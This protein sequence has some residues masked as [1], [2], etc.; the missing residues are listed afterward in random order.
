MR[1]HFAADWAFGIKG[2]I[3]NVV[4]SNFPSDLRNWPL[5]QAFDFEAY[6]L[7]EFAIFIFKDKLSGVPAGPADLKDFPHNGYPELPPKKEEIELWH[8]F[9]KIKFNLR[10]E[11]FAFIIPIHDCGKNDASEDYKLFTKEEKEFWNYQL[12]Y[13]ISNYK[14]HL[15]SMKEKTP[16]QPMNITYNVSGNN[17]RVNI[18]STDNSVNIVET[19]DLKIFQDL[20]D[21]ASKI[22]NESER[23]NV[24]ESIEAMEAEAGKEKFADK[25]KNFISTAANHMTLFAPFIPPLTELITKWV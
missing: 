3:E 7:G 24:I 6:R 10:T 2:A 25:Y 15:D 12:S 19:N 18:D 1:S 21:I 5:L 11:D 8:H 4:R 14:A 23:I 22:E 17:A 9:F 20:K 13:N 16:E